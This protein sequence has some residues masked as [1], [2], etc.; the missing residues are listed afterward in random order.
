M[1]QQINKILDSNQLTELLKLAREFNL[2]RLKVGD[3]EFQFHEKA[4]I[5]PVE[6]DKPV[7]AKELMIESER[8]KKEDEELK[9]W[10][11]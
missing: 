9:Y 5:E 7:S 2:L 8:R 1:T 3:I 10:S 6:P 4:F 11:S